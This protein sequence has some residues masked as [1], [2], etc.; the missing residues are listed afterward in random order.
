M[1]YHS[2]VRSP[3]PTPRVTPE[4]ARK[5]SKESDSRQASVTARNQPDDVPMAASMPLLTAGHDPLSIPSEPIPSQFSPTGISPMSGMNP[6]MNPVAMNMQNISSSVLAFTAQAA[7]AVMANML[8]NMNPNLIP[9]QQPFSNDAFMLALQ[10]SMRNHVAAGWPVIQPQNGTF[11]SSQ[12]VSPLPEPPLP[13]PSAPSSS[14]RRKTLKSWSPMSEP[15]AV[16]SV[17]SASEFSRRVENKEK[18]SS[19]ATKR[20]KVSSSSAKDIEMDDVEAPSRINPST[21]EKLFRTKSGRP[22]GFFVQIEIHNRFNL[23]SSIKVGNIS[24]L[25]LIFDSGNIDSSRV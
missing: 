3:L 7:Q 24:F 16:R 9:N 13:Y 15:S 21:D 25:T 10:D 14:K 18:I 22:L 11:S 4:D 1:L 5:R 17:S 6:F 20:R 8:M 12:S 19:P 23:V 2:C